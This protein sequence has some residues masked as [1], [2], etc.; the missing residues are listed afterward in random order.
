[1]SDTTYEVLQNGQAYKVR[2]TCLGDFIREADGFSTR[3]AAESWITQARRLGAIRAGQQ[4]PVY[5]PHL[6]VV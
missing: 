6:R 5:S 4:K 3:A 2:I 1:M